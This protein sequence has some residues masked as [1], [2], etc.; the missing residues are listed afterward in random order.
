M[1]LTGVKSLSYGANMQAT[2]IAKARGADEALLVR[3]DGDRARG[4]D[5]DDLLGHADGELRTPALETGILDS[6][7]RRALIDELEVAEGEFE[8][9]DLLARRA[10]RS[11]P[12]PRARCSR[13]SAIDDRA[14]DARAADAPRRRRRSLAAIDA[15]ARSGGRR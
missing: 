4:A 1:I 9:D 3:P 8:L 11:S 13:S 12:R 2:R 14:L 15:G 10:R 5:L 6:I 7:T